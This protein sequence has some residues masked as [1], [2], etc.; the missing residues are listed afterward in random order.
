[1]AVGLENEV[2]ELG[3]T[4]ERFQKT[5]PA[6][7]KLRWSVVDKGKLDKLIN[8]LKEHN[9][10]LYLVLPGNHVSQHSIG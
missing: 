1:V 10:N 8:Q 4:A 3:A 5:L 2:K 9:M 6:L 7:S